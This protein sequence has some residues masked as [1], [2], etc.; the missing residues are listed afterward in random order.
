M[1]V[2][3]TAPGSGARILV[4]DDEPAIRKLFQWML[5]NAGYQV[6]TASN[7]DEALELLGKEKFSLVISD[8]RMPGL[9]GLD[10]LKASKKISAETQVIIASGYV[11]PDVISNCMQLGAA[12]LLEKPFTINHLLTTVNL[13][14]ES[15]PSTTE[16]MGALIGGQT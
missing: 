7:G 11:E 12:H 15:H 3:I 16:P 14:L 1:N 5:K 9:N 13:V 2:T 8:L 6:I 4:V 10:V